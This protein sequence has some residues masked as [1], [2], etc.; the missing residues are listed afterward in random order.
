[1]ARDNRHNPQ[2]R[3]NEDEEKLYDAVKAD[4]Q[5]AQRALGGSD[6][7]TDAAVF[8]YALVQFGRTL[9][10]QAPQEIAQES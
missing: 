6:K 7:V 8:R 10:E 9:Q 3:L 2:I 4:L 5:C 1:M